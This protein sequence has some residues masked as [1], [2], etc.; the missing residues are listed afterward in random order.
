M[1]VDYIVYLFNNTTINWRWRHYHKYYYSCEGSEGSFS[2]D[3]SR[4]QCTPTD[5]LKHWQ[6]HNGPEGWVQLTKVQTSSNTNLDQISSLK[7]QTWASRLNLKFKIL[8]KPSIRISTKNQLQNLNQTSA[9]RL[10]LKFKI[11]TKT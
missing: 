5:Q 1:V 4:F 7:S 3:E 9:Y 11:L 2:N 8:N 6:R 10:N